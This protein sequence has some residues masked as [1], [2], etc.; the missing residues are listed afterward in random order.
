MITVMTWDTNEVFATRKAADI[1]SMQLMQHYALDQYRP[2]LEGQNRNQ[3]WEPDNWKRDQKVKIWLATQDEPQDKDAATMIITLCFYVSISHQKHWKNQ[4]NDIPS[5]EDEPVNTMKIAEAGSE[6]RAYVKVLATS[7]MFS[8][9]YHAEK[10]TIAGICNRQTC[11]A[12]ADP[13]SI[14]KDSVL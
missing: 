13:I 6:W 2:P 7:P 8:G 1:L 4:C 11:N 10:A 5:W 3:Q 9:S 12:Y 14:L